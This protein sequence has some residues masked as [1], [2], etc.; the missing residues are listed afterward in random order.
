MTHMLLANLVLIDGSRARGIYDQMMTAYNSARSSGVQAIPPFD[1]W[2]GVTH[3]CD[4]YYCRL[5]FSW[6]V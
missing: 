2:E 4:S 5:V 6:I 3:Y 1:E